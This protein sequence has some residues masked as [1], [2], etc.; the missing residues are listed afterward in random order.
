M[1]DQVTPPVAPETQAPPTPPADNKMDL[2]AKKERQLRQMQKQLAEEKQ[3]LSAKAAEY[4]TGYI[5]KS[6]LKES[7][8]DVLAEAGLDYDTLA[9]QLMEQQNMND[10][11]TRA[12]MNKIKQLEAKQTAA[13][14]AQADATE[15]QYNHAIKQITND[16]KILVSSN[17]D[18][19]TIKELGLEDSVVELIRETFETDGTLMD[20]EAA[21]KQVEDEALEQLVKAT[22]LKKLQSRITPKVEEP[23]PKLQSQPKVTTLTNGQTQTTTKKSG[24]KDR[25]ARAIAAFNNKLT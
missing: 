21:C 14:K 7:P 24:E 11:A 5:P 18:F 22:Q 15:A 3:R 23:A 19:E 12:L 20:V 6:R 4:E 1:S 2:Y 9:Q 17:A 25:I 13:E 10:P 16:V 8:F